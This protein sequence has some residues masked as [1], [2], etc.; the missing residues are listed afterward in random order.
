MTPLT[1]TLN[2]GSALSFRKMRIGLEKMLI[3][4]IKVF[5]GGI[6]HPMETALV[7][8]FFCE[9]NMPNSVSMR[10]MGVFVTSVT[11]L[12]LL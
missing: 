6:C 8:N 5:I 3:T 12:F 9:D 10:H 11:K 2:L 1:L 7:L 4:S